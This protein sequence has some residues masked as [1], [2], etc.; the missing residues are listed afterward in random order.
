MGVYGRKALRLHG[1]AFSV[2][3]AFIGHMHAVVLL[4][5]AYWVI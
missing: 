1:R 4:A 2:A 5:D 3:M